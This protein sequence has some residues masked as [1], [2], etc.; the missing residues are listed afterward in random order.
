MRGGSREETGGLRRHYRAHTDHVQYGGLSQIRDGERGDCH[1]G[2]RYRI[3]WL[4]RGRAGVVQGFGVSR[5]ASLVSGRST[6]G[7]STRLAACTSDSRC[8]GKMRSTNTGLR[9]S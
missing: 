1:D 6:S 9:T 2:Q 3:E 5:T 7:G 4:G 8:W